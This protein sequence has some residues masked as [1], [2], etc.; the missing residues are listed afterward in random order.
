M[1]YSTNDDVSTQTKLD[2]VTT[3]FPNS[4]AAYEALV[5]LFLTL[6]Y[7]EPRKQQT[8]LLPVFLQS[9]ELVPGEG[10]GGQFDQPAQ[11]SGRQPAGRLHAHAWPGVLVPDQASARAQALLLPR[12]A[13]G[14]LL[15]AGLVTNGSGSATVLPKW[16]KTNGGTER[17]QTRAQKYP[18]KTS[19]HSKLNNT[20]K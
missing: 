19:N 5:W 12:R 13:H 2:S 6:L 17:G 20:H 14:A 3:P 18:M 11:H 7:S 10:R 8:S 9:L 16:L 1:E 15:P 4:G